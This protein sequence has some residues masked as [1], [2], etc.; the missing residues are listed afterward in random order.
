MRILGITKR[1]MAESRE[2][3]EINRGLELENY[4]SDLQETRT[5]AWMEAPRLGPFPEDFDKDELASHI[6]GN[7]AQ[8]EA[9]ANEA[10]V[11]LKIL[12][13]ELAAYRDDV[14]ISNTEEYASASWYRLIQFV[15]LALILWRLW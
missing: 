2:E 6:G 1:P 3:A 4:L 7:L 5:Q 8:I 11:I 14:M 10:V 15:L 12:K 9:M 13:V